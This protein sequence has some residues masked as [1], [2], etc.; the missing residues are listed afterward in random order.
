MRGPG[1]LRHGIVSLAGFESAQEAFAALVQ[2]DPYRLSGM[3]TYSNVLY[4]LD[5]RA[6]LSAVAQRTALHCPPSPTTHCIQGNLHS[7]RGQHAQAIQC[8]REA[9]KLDPEYLS[10]WTLMGHEHVELRETSEAVACY[11]RAVDIGPRDFRAW[12]GLAQTY[13]MLGLP[14]F[15]AYYYQQAAALRPGDPRMWCA[16]G[17]VFQSSNQPGPAAKCYERAHQCNDR[18]GLASIRLA[19]LA[20]EGGDDAGA[21]KYYKE[22]LSLRE[23]LGVSAAPCFVSVQMCMLRGLACAG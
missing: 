20:R 7:A 21:C 14:H 17:Y 3:D 15:A 9:L 22:H 8:F 6:E 23:A 16:L 2:R 11:R 12:Y 1:M 13:E 5:D 19:Q 10:A 4:V 18:E